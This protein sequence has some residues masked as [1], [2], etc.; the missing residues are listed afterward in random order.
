VQ[1]YKNL[2]N[3]VCDKNSIPLSS[4][5]GGLKKANQTCIVNLMFKFVGARYRKYDKSITRNR[6]KEYRIQDLGY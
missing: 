2:K 4:G 3:Y 6:I 1:R 5:G